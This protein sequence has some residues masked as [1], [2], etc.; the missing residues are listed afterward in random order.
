MIKKIKVEQLKRGMF[1]HDFNC[2]WLNHPFLTNAI[3]INDE[4]IV[5]KAD[6]GIME[7]IL[8]RT[9]DMILAAR[10][11]NMRLSRRSRLK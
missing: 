3:K 10:R 6:Y 2:S 1:V 5:Q 8:T 4:Q 7:P 9:E 11:Q